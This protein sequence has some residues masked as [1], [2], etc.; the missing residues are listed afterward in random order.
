MYF[1]QQLLRSRSVGGC[2][3]LDG[4]AGRFCPVTVQHALN[5]VGTDAL[6]GRLMI[7][8]YGSS[9]QV[10]I[11]W[12]GKGKALLGNSK[13]LM[14][15][16]NS[17]SPVQTAKRQTEPSKHPVQHQYRP[18]ALQQTLSFQKPAVFQSD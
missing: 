16:S 4:G 15:C 1:A 10:R 9:A 14:G 17:N 7:L 8:P 11:Q 13:Y 18:L 2:Q 3:L 6:K 12:V 5:L